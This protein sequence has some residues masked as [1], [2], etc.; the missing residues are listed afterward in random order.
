MSQKDISR[1]RRA[2]KVRARIARGEKPRL[3]VFRSS[4]HIYAQ[5]LTPAGDRTL[6][7]ASTVE[8]ATRGAVKSTGNREA[9]A[10]VGKTIAEKALAEG[11]S[12]V[13]FDRSGFKFHGR[14]KSLAEAAREAGLK[15]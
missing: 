9:A 11:I 7:T 15:F 12:E 1:H 13:A 4:R 2:R 3:S 10:A 14:V 6:V 8:V 5:V